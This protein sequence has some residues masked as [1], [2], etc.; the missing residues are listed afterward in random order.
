MSFFSFIPAVDGVVSKDSAHPPSRPMGA[1]GADRP[2]RGP[3]R[4]GGETPRFGD[5]KGYRN[6]NGFGGEKGGVP[7]DYRLDFKSRK[8]GGCGFGR[9]GGGGFNSGGSGRLGAI[10]E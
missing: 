5:K 3:P 8:S 9:R 4:E 6:S 1:P 10:I 2:P 7:K